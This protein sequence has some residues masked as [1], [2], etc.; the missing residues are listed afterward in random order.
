[1]ADLLIVIGV[2]KP[3]GLEPLNG[4]SEVCQ[5]V[6]R[7]GNN[8]GFD[9]VPI[10]DSSAEV[11]AAAIQAALPAAE[12]TGRNRVIVY[13][14]GHGFNVWGQVAWVLSPGADGYLGL[15]GVEEFK[16]A[17]KTYGV[18]NI[19]ILGDAC[20]TLA[21]P[22][23]GATAILPPGP[24]AVWP[25]CPAD[26]FY[27]AIPGQS[28]LVLK[29]D[30]GQWRP[31]FSGAL[32][33]ALT[34]V[35]LPTGASDQQLSQ[36]R[37]LL[38]TSQSLA[39]YLERE[40]DNR[41]AASGLVQYA[42][43]NSGLRWPDNIYRKF[44]VPAEPKLINN[45]SIESIVDGRPPSNSEFQSRRDDSGKGNGDDLQGRLTEAIEE[46]API[47]DA[48]RNETYR[49]KTN[50]E[51]RIDFWGNFL[52]RAQGNKNPGSI[53][54]VTEAGATPAK[55]Q[56]QPYRD[57]ALIAIDDRLWS[58]IPRYHNAI[59]GLSAV[60][61]PDD[62]HQRGIH[63]IG[64]HDAYQW[65]DEIKIDPHS[66]WASADDAMRVLKGFIS[67]TLNLTELQ[68]TMNNYRV[69]KHVNPVFGIVASYYYFSA[70][71]IDSVIRTAGFYE[72][73]YQPIPI[74]IALMTGAELVL[75]GGMVTVDL[76][77]IPEALHTRDAPKYLWCAAPPKPKSPVAGL[78]PVFRAGWSHF[79]GARSD[80]SNLRALERWLTNSPITAF[81]SPNG[82]NDFLRIL[83][84]MGDGK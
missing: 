74:D 12:L 72:K 38:I 50:S 59:C 22:G 77:A 82:Y 51:W 80:L 62:R 46:P 69:L 63:A 73:H 75:R 43:A 48:K 56:L 11:S 21:V 26:T 54:V 20:Q 81:D 14:C 13:F 78:L 39:A 79:A 4:V 27:A 42:Y 19:S 1:M 53:E 55:V 5:S 9:V 83:A 68:A 30:V 49:A 2:A 29:E 36:A 44:V 47:S 67:G 57:S 58:I 71:D 35:P 84:T 16:R 10:L 70:G 25:P 40:V 34:D 3:K 17:L 7:W 33:D 65:L 15:L 37:E 28:A 23:L 41:S 18:R 32:C 61:E 6:I 60:T 64:W 52:R 76:P 8:S 31:V 24:A 45:S 66:T